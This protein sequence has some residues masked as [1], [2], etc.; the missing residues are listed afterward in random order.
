LDR[1]FNPVDGNHEFQ[2]RAVVGYAGQETP[3]LKPE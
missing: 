2:T 1:V 3:C